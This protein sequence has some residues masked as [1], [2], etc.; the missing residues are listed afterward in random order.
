MSWKCTDCNRELIWGGDHD[1]EAYGIVSNL[2]CQN[3]RC[4]VEMIIIYRK[5]NNL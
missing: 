2:S 5:I 4:N 1:E 3:K